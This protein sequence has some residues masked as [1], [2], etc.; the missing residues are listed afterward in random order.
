MCSAPRS[1][2]GRFPFGQGVSVWKFRV[3][4]RIDGKKNFSGKAYSNLATL[5][6]SPNLPDDG[7]NLSLSLPVLGPK[8]D[9]ALLFDSARK[10]GDGTGLF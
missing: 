3:R 5:P 7:I 1:K 9:C 4:S 2:P 8:G 10:K 6:G